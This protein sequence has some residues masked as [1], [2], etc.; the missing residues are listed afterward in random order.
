MCGYLIIWSN[1]F[2]AIAVA[3][4][5]A[6]VAGTKFLPPEEGV[7]VEVGDAFKAAPHIVSPDSAGRRYA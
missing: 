5:G 4:G 3:Q 7:Q 6:W 1:F 2:L